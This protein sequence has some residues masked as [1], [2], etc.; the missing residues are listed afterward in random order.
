MYEFFDWLI[1][2]FLSIWDAISSTIY[3]VIS[4]LSHVWNGF[5]FVQQVIWDM[6][7]FCQGALLTIAG[8][9]LATV[10]ISAFVDVA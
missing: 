9:S 4:M 8:I 1:G 7:P 10:L 3:S 2:I 5:L 6:P